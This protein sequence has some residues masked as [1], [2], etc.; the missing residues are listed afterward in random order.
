MNREME[1]YGQFGSLNCSEPE[2]KPS[3]EEASAGEDEEA[4]PGNQ[5]GLDDE[6]AATAASS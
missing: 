2:D 1:Y 3:V 5:E 6:E 4:L